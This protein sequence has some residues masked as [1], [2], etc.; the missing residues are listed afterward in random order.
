MTSPLSSLPVDSS[1][2]R[3]SPVRV[4]YSG[5]DGVLRGDTVPP[6]HPA[7]NPPGTFSAPDPNRDG[8]GSPGYS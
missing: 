6:L 1:Y 8:H 5:R 4:T 3:E 2:P 7:D